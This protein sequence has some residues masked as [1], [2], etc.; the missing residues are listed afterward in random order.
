MPR[1]SRVHHRW[2]PRGA[3]PRASDNSRLHLGF[4]DFCHGAQMRD[5]HFDC[6]AILGF[7]GGA[8]DE[9]GYSKHHRADFAQVRGGIMG[10][11]RQIAFVRTIEQAFNEAFDFLRAHL[12]KIA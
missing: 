4:H 1:R 12:A 9:V 3:R 10:A 6:G 7:V 11:L 2:R 5:G 8:F